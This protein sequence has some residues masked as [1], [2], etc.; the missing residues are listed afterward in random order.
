MS[1]SPLCTWWGTVFCSFAKGYAVM[2]EG[3]PGG[4][5]LAQEKVHL[6]EEIGERWLSNSLLLGTFLWSYQNVP[7]IVPP[8]SMGR[9]AT[10]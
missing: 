10:C 9:K 1:M 3:E 5:R 7:T 8:L 4:S 2:L 6:A